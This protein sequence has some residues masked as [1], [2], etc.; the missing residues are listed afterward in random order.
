[1]L[2]PIFLP[3]RVSA[4]CMTPR[5]RTGGKVLY[6][7][8]A[9]ESKSLGRLWPSENQNR[10]K[11]VSQK[12]EQS[13]ESEGFYFLPTPLTTPLTTPLLTFRLWSSKNQTVGVGS[14]RGRINQ[15]QCMF[16]HFAIG[17]VLPLQ[18]AT[19]TTQFSLYC[20]RRIRKRNQN[21]VFTRLWLRHQW[22]PALDGSASSNCRLD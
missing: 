6:L 10:K 18:L 16:P 4:A 11:S 1:M 8:L 14:R 9:P 21:A 2:G 12:S 7:K 13:E 22:K 19:S 3:A 5:T 20:K 15:S 17:S